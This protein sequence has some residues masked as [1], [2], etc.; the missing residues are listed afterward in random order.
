M[1]S[2]HVSFSHVQ[3]RLIPELDCLSVKREITPFQVGTEP[4]LLGNNSWQIVS[5]VR[6][7]KIARALIFED[8][9]FRRPVLLQ[10]RVSVQMIRGQV[11]P[12][13]YGRTKGRNRL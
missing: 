1:N 2:A 4:N 8:P 7:R 13:G 5:I 3:D 11:Q 12:N 6:H 9:Q 10:V